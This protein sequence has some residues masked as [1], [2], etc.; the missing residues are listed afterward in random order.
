M[1]YLLKTIAIVLILI[2]F[3]QASGQNNNSLINTPPINIRLS[4]LVY[5]KPARSP[6][7]KNRQE[8]QHTLNALQEVTRVPGQEL[9][10]I[11]ADVWALFGPEEKDFFSVKGQ[12]LMVSSG[13]VLTCLSIWAFIRLIL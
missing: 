6:E 5:P 2:P 11:A 13:L 12:F 8:T 4:D 9:E 3:D 1:K 7:E 10:A